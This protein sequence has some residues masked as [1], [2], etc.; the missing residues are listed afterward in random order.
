MQLIAIAGRARCGKGTVAQWFGKERGAFLALFAFPIKQ[1]LIGMFGPLCGLSWDH[2][3]NDD[4]KEAPL[5]VIGV[6][7]R[8]LAQTLGTEFGRNC[9]HQDVWVMQLEAFLASCRVWKKPGQTIVLHDLRFE[10]EAAWVRANGGTIIHLTRPGADGAV[11]VPGHA[12]E[13]GII[14]TTG[15]LLIEN[16]GTIAKLHA[17]LAELFPQRA[18]A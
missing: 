9:V 14:P 16:D 12:S 18:A 5:P 17:K 8:K 13:A 11:G 10:N 7:P 4:L 15:D 2:F 1:A 3:E 6:S